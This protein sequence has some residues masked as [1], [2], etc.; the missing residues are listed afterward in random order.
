ML[1]FIFVS[2]EFGL[3]NG[4][5]SQDFPFAQGVIASLL[6]NFIGVLLPDSCPPFDNCFKA[7]AFPASKYFL[8]RLLAIKTLFSSF[9]RMSLRVC[10]LLINIKFFFAS[11]SNNDHFLMILSKIFPGKLLLK[12][13]AFTCCEWIC[14]CTVPHTIALQ[15]QYHLKKKK[16]LMVT[17]QGQ[18]FADGPYECNPLNQHYLIYQK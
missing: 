4:N 11:Q 18:F 17:N 9:Q 3:V 14:F 13:S 7:K 5:V 2:W 16:H 15:W 6:L 10:N 8:L 1:I 12:V